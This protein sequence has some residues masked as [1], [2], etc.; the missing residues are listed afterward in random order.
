MVI[1]QM[2]EQVDHFKYLGSIISEDIV[3]MKLKV[4][5]Q[6]ERKLS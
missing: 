6:W 2:V 5:L 3:T 1:A 4:G